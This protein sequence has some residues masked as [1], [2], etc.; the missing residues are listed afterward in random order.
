MALYLQED[1]SGIIKT[2]YS[3]CLNLLKF[4]EENL[5]EVASK[6][7]IDKLLLNELMQRMIESIN[8][9]SDTAKYTTQQ[10][11]L[12]EISLKLLNIHKI[13]NEQNIARVD[14]NI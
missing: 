5:Q 7:G 4:V 1:N 11:L 12:L 14:T 8:F 6:G 3:S 9:E 10:K 13:V 2:L